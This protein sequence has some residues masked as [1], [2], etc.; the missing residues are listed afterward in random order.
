MRQITKNGWWIR[1]KMQD[2]VEDI[3]YQ[4]HS[5]GIKDEVLE[6][7]HSL[8]RHFYT[9]GDKIEEAYRIVKQKREGYE[10]KYLDKQRRSN[11]R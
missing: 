9:Y 11:K 8:N 4:A 5:E 7:S 2:K 6:V 3:L 10:N 1:R